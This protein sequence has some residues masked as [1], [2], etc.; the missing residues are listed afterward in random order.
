MR[1]RSHAGEASS[2]GYFCV[3]DWIAMSKEERLDHFLTWLRAAQYPH[4]P[5]TAAPF[6]TISQQAGA[7][8]ETLARHL[9]DRLNIEDKGDTPWSVWDRE[10]VERIVAE[11]HI[12][13][14]VLDQFETIRKGNWLADLFSGFSSREDPDTHNTAEIYRKIARVI[15]AIATKGRA[16]LVGRGGMYVTT[17][18]PGGIHVRLVAPLNDRIRS[19]AAQTK[20]DWKKASD[21]VQQIEQ[22][23]LAF[24]HQFFPDKPLQPDNFTITLNTAA[25]TIEQQVACILPLVLLRK[26][27]SEAAVTATSFD[28]GRT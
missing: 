7:G 25:A 24:Y 26:Q 16:V 13:E 19:Y 20:L 4:P 5:H 15:R 17:D 27:T 28:A 18:L 23:R 21:E 10:L 1:L 9:A 14:S 8:G 11:E 22:R 12:P 2:H 3:H 6:I